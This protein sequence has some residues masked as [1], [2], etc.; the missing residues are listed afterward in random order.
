MP[1]L[2]TVPWEI[3]LEDRELIAFIK[4]AVGYSLTGDIREQCLFVGHGTGANGKST[5]LDMLG[6]VL[7]SMGR[8][9]RRAP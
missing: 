3:F 8:R 2:V 7:G 5:L 6:D 4:R 9:C 1:N